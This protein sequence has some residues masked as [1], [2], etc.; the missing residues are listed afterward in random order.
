M[1]EKD[2]ILRLATQAARAIAQIMAFKQAGHYEE[3]LSQIDH[4]LEEFLGL[5]ATMAAQLS[6]SELILICRFGNVLDKD[7]ALLL[8]T[9]L[10]EEG[11]LYA[12]EDKASESHTRYIKSL[13]LTLEALMS[14]DSSLAREYL[15][16]VET[17]VSKLKESEIDLDLRDDLWRYYNH[18]G[19]A[20]TARRYL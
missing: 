2:Y 8:A 19:D 6:A 16:F 18:I 1:Y 9:L 15:P 12:V 13:T 14:A 20:T 3:A 11:D 10:K 4:T 7:K 17:L 5:R